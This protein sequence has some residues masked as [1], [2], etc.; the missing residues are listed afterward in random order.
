[1]LR[2]WQYRNDALHE[3]D[4]KKVA[5]FKV[6]ALDID[7]ERME[8][9]PDAQASHFSRTAYARSGTCEHITT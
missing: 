4:T 1:M 9:R 6:E 3:N 7:I 5:Q 2:L 8:A